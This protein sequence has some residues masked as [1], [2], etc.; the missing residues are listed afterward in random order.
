MGRNAYFAYTL[1]KGMG[2]PW[3]TALGCVF[4]SG[5]AFLVLTIAGVR[6]LIVR[7]VPRPLF[8]AVA[9]GTRP[10]L[11][12]LRLPPARLLIPPA[13]AMVS[14]RGPTPPPAPL[15]LLRLPP[16]AP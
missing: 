10:F 11:S 5:V 9:G 13:G 7:A 6:Q 4:I 15:A 14:L 8:A 1:V 16:R 12:F 2:L 3:Q